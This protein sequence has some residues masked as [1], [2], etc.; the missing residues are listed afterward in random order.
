MT[1]MLE[2]SEKHFKAA[3]IKMLQLTFC[4]KQMKTD[5]G[6][7]TGICRGKKE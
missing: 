4:L 3:I 1:Q 5:F 6:K 7:E 2:L